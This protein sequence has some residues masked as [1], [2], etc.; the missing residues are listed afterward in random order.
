MS[1]QNN[2]VL[3]I[4]LVRGFIMFWIIGG[5]QIFKAI[6]TFN[7]HVLVSFLDRQMQHSE[8]HGLTFYDLIFPCFIFLSGVSL[9]LRPQQIQRLSVDVRSR[10]YQQSLRR[11]GLLVLLG[12]VYNHGWGVGIPNSFDDIRYASVL[13]KI[14]V[15]WLVSA[16]VVWHCTMRGQIWFLIGL[17]CL[18]G[19]LQHSVSNLGWVT[20][21]SAENSLNTWMDQHY[22][23]GV[24]Y[25]SNHLDSEGLL[26][27]I[28]SIINALIGAI[29]SQLVFREGASN[30][31]KLAQL[32]IFSMISLNL[33]WFLSIWI[34]VNKILWT[35]SFALFS[36]GYCILMLAAALVISDVLKLRAL[37]VFFSVIGFNSIAIY[38]ST[39][40]FD[41]HYLE[42]SLFG[43]WI[44]ILPAILQPFAWVLVAITIKWLL[45]AYCYEKRWRLKV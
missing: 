19:L 7:P 28:G 21:Y 25:Q 5:D 38:L 32:L 20:N 34:P 2:R 44:V 13:A 17:V 45:L 27:N 42:S 37:T 30:K 3:A 14:A 23:P 1:I 24:F 6:G 39:S 43:Q 29:I 26:G 41:W 36:S 16:M 18:Y 10:L 22:L 12:I 40:L 31:L 11:F 35:V 33:G 4:D 8:W 9:G 15:A